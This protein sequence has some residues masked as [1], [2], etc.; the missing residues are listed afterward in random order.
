MSNIQIIIVGW[1]VGQFGYAAVSVYNLQKDKPNI[2]YLQAA[3]AY[4]SKEIGSFIMAFAGLAILIFI[5]PDFWDS[6]INRMDLRLKP[7]LTWKERIIVYQRCTAVVLGGL[8]QHLLYIIYKRGKKEIAK[9]DN[10]KAN[11]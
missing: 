9:L 5:F 2:N 1:L 8:S 10:E 6:D 4:F 3:G 11:D 7:V